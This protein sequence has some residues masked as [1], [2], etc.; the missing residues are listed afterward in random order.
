M[1]GRLA[2]G[3]ILARLAAGVAVTA[4]AAV[5]G[6]RAYGGVDATRQATERAGVEAAA[7]TYR[8]IECLDA[9]VAEV[10]PAGTRVFVA[11]LDSLWLQRTMVAAFPELEVVGSPD[12]AEVVL[13]LSNPAA[14]DACG[15][16]PLRVVPV[17][18]P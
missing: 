15:P 3:D 1:R 12:A 11:V 17:P 2:G 10:A 4:A 13:D 8:Q 6:V 14:P 7:E 9:A 16:E 5:V 18:A